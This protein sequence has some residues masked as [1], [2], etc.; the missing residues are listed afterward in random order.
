MIDIIN[1]QKVYKE[2]ASNYNIDISRIRLKYEHIL[3]VMENSGYIAR[4]LKL[5]E[6]E[7][8]LAMLIG[9]FHDRSP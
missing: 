5:T 9:I 7:I 6:E 8:N 2:Y 4:E 3:R 1:A